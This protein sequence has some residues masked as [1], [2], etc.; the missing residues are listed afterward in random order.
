MRRNVRVSDTPPPFGGDYMYAIAS[1]LLMFEM[2]S[3]ILY[4]LNKPLSLIDCLQLFMFSVF[5]DSG[6]AESENLHQ[7]TG[8]TLNI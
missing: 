3:T 7:T 5:K 4:M 8:E 1:R 2:S 6:E